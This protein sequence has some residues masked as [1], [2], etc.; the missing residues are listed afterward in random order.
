MVEV[1]I[2]NLGDIYKEG[3]V[4]NEPKAGDCDDDKEVGRIECRSV[5][6][7]RMRIASDRGEGERCEHL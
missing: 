4:D 1:P 2:A 7:S 5:E 3:K 6:E